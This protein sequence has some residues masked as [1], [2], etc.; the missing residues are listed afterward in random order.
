MELQ[1]ALGDQLHGLSTLMELILLKKM[2]DLTK[3]K[4]G[5]LDLF[6][7]MEKH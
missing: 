3:R 7:V 6:V 5:L 2:K 1:W 4:Y